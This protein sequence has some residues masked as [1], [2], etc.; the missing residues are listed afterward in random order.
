MTRTTPEMSVHWADPAFGFRPGGKLR[1][2]LGSY[3]ICVD[4]KPASGAHHKCQY[5]L[6]K[7]QRKKRSFRGGAAR[8]H[9]TARPFQ[10]RENGLIHTVY[11]SL[12]RGGA[13][14]GRVKARPSQTG[15]TG[16]NRNASKKFIAGWSSP[17]ARQAHNLK[18]VSSNLAPATKI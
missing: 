1:K 9:A 16:L 15:K 14:K 18:V 8:G 5:P 3:R 6:G 2:L 17:V 7:A 4:V 11:T 12:S 13:A 10:T